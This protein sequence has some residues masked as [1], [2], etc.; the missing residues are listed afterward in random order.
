MP[1]K[2]PELFRP[3]HI[4]KLELKNKIVMAPMLIAG[5]FDENAGLTDAAIDFYEARA[6]GGTG[7]I[8]TCAFTANA[9]TEKKG[10]GKE[11][12]FYSPFDHPTSFLT[13]MK[14]L[15]DRI[16]PYGTKLFIQI[17]LGN[18]RVMRPARLE[19][20]PVSASD[21]PNFWEPD[22]NCRAMTKKEIEALV[23]SAV[24]GAVLSQKSGCDGV[25]IVGVYGGY[26]ADQFATDVFNHRTDE[27]GGSIDGQLK[28]MTDV[29]KGIKQ[30]C[31]NDFPVSVR[32]GL[33]HHAKAE[34]HGALAGE[35]YVE[36][37]RDLCQSI[38]IAKKLEQSGCDALLLGSGCYD[39]LYWLY[40]PMYQKDGLWLEEA[41]QLIG[42]V[43]IPI[44]CPGKITTPKM[45]NS[46]IENGMVTAVALG[47]ALL[48]DPEWPNK[49]KMGHDDA[50]RPCIGCNNGCIARDFAR[51]PMGCAVNAD[52]FHEKTADLNKVEVPKNISIIGGGI[53]GMEAARIAAI[54]GHAVTIY[55]KNQKLGGMTVAAAV[56]EFKDADR[57]LLCWYEKE[58]NDTGVVVK[59]GQ[60]VTLE[61]VKELDYDEIVVATG[62]T[63][64]T[65]PI[66]GVNLPHVTTAIEVLLGK[67][68][69]GENVTVIG[70]GQVG[71]ELAVWLREKGK[72]VTLVE[73][74][75]GL[76]TGGK[77]GVFLA[78][79]LMLED[80]LAY[81]EVRTLLNTKVKAI[82]PQHLEVEMGAFD[83]LIPADT[84]VMAIGYQADNGLFKEISQSVPKKI[85]LVGDA[86]T[87]SNIMY[88]VKDGATIG[89]AL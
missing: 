12:P 4:G 87:P 14:K 13:Q 40:P 24:D 78:N 55:E 74:M 11:L 18:G 80:M 28:L 83:E 8:Y 88:A 47:R 36:F 27:Y 79:R 23:K 60:N 62:A 37:G 26:L 89:R 66:P 76:M 2:Y 17:S 31:G 44:I 42:H 54:R 73:A 85:W 75:D 32:L 51:L 52:L 65:P 63:P 69:P 19:E 39:S 41:S 86:N 29:V 20:R 77:E 38:E 43:G 72:Q 81:H 35:E 49:A 22:T 6:R 84:V 25:D 58:L 61:Q 67:T 82:T 59:C 46:A 64:K 9:A 15:S 21:V 45:A 56:P 5:W 48:A 7:L 70:G 34:R 1:L 71:C 16:H 30:A 50:I 10:L 57:R 33:K 3:F 53:A 68:E